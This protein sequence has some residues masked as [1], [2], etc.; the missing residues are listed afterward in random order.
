[1]L[2]VGTSGSD[3]Q[4]AVGQRVQHF[5]GLAECR[6]RWASCRAAP[7]PRQGGRARGDK[8]C[9]RQAPGAARRLGLLCATSGG[10]R[11]R[12]PRRA[13]A[14]PAGTPFGLALS[15]SVY[16]H[17]RGAY[18]RSSASLQV[19]GGSREVGPAHYFV[20]I[21]QIA[22]QFEV[23]AVG[24]RAV[25]CSPQPCTRVEKRVSWVLGLRGTP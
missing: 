1:M 16:S 8:A 13:T 24:S 25:Q 12:P 14:G 19:R 4:A 20:A 5:T 18:S 2:V 22:T 23:F 11:R 7:L 15:F 6:W 3:L 17:N 9:F 21:V 10:P